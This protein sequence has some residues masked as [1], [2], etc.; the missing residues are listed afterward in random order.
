VAK[1]IPSRDPSWVKEQVEEFKRRTE[2]R[3]RLA[4]TAFEAQDMK[5]QEVLE[6]IRDNL[7]IGATGEIR[8]YKAGKRTESA[9]VQVEL[10][11]IEDNALWM[12]TEILKDLAMMDI[13]VAGYKFPDVYCAECGTKLHKPKKK[14]GRK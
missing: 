1:K 4:L 8:V 14:K 11:L 12:A 10:K 6:R 7:V 5:T 3:A 9:T 13:K 2:I